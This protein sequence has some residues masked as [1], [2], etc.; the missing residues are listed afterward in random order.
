MLKPKEQKTSNIVKLRFKINRV[1]M[2]LTSV[3]APQSLNVVVEKEE[4]VEMGHVS[5]SILD[6][7]SEQF[8]HLLSHESNSSENVFKQL[9]VAQSFPKKLG[10]VNMKDFLRL[11]IT[12]QIMD[13]PIIESRDIDEDRVVA[14]RRGFLKTV[15][16][17]SLLA[18]SGTETL[19]AAVKPSLSP[20]T[21]ALEHLHTGDKLKLTYFEQGRY[22][23]DALQ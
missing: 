9:K 7:A 1:M 17:A 13:K 6:I 22:I 3:V 8:G 14:S 10:Q 23:G 21:L 2:M 5:Q 20:K 18:L 12:R 4:N 16:S 19:N 11:R 15:A